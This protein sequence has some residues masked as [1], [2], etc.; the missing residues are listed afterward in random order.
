MCELLNFDSYKLSGQAA[1]EAKNVCLELIDGH[2]TFT[3]HGIVQ[4]FSKPHP[5]R[6]C[7]PTKYISA[8]APEILYKQRAPPQPSSAGQG[9]NAES[10]TDSSEVSSSV[11]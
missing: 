4:L 6:V 5:E 11:F 8:K 7:T 2:K 3:D 1:I 9:E 10:L